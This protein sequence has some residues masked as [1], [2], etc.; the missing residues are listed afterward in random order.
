MYAQYYSQ[1]STVFHNE[2]FKTVDIQRSLSQAEG[3]SID[4]EQQ[5]LQNILELDRQN[6]SQN[7]QNQSSH[8]PVS[9]Q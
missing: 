6:R 5:L 1:A 2:V 8:A 3:Q 7:H 4:I 9:S